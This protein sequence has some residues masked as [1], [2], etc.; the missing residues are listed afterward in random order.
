MK[1]RKRTGARM[2]RERRD[3]WGSWWC[4]VG[5]LGV[6]GGERCLVGIVEMEDVEADD[7]VNP[8]DT[9]KRLLR[10][11]CEHSNTQ[12]MASFS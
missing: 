7:G 9:Q 12:G 6:V 5:E 2:V 11:F 10:L 1:D 4:G 8:R 3:S